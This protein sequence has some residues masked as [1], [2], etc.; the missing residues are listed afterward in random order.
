MGNLQMI[1]LIIVKIVN[2]LI[3]QKQLNHPWKLLKNPWMTV[4]LHTGLVIPFVMMV[5]TLLNVDLMVEIAAIMKMRVGTIIVK[6][7][8]ALISQRQR[9]LLM[10]PIVKFQSGSVMIIAMTTTTI[11]N[12]VLMEVPAVE[13]TS[14][15]TTALNVNALHCLV[16]THIVIERIVA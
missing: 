7:V 10:D 16:K 11:L 14:T 9:K 12:V 13:T 2:A 5:I 15:P 6:S 8:N 3:C 1:G 4:L